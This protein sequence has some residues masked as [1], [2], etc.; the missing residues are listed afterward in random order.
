MGTFWHRACTLMHDVLEAFDLART[1]RDFP[2][3]GGLLR[4]LVPSTLLANPLSVLWDSYDWRRT[5]RV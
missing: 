2:W 4:S 1:R 3:C 5:P